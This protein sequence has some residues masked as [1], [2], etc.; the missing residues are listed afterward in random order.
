[1]KKLVLLALL[2]PALALAIYDMDTFDVNHWRTPV[3]NDGRWGFDVTGPGQ[4]GGTWPQPLHNCYVFGAGPWFGAIVDSALPETLCTHMYY[5]NS[6]GSE[7]SP[8]LC[9]YWRDG[10]EDSLD[11]IY[12]YP[13]DW[14]PPL[15]RFPM[16]PQVPRA[17]MEMWCGFGDSLAEN[18][19]P[20]GRPLGIDVYQTVY[21]F[22]DSVA[23]DFFFLKYELANCSGDSLRQA[24][25]GMMFDPDIGQHTDDM[26]GLIRDRLFQVGPD[27]IRVKDVGYAYDYDTIENPGS[28]WES[29]TPGIVAVMVLSTPESLGLTAFKKSLCDVEDT[30]TDAR[31]YMNLAGYD[32]ETGT[33]APYDTVDTVPGDKVELFATGPYDIAPDSVLT[34]WYV[35]IAS[36]CDLSELAR[37][38]KDATDIYEERLTGIEETPSAEARTPNGAT[39]VRG[40]LNL[41]PA[42][43]SPQSEIVLLDISGR[44]VMALRPGANDVRALAPGVYFVREAQAQD[45][46]KVLATK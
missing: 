36:P 34:F 7:M 24:Y 14:P 42:I 21:G 25:F 30:W 43:Y 44:K 16:A 35:V 29:G 2:V 11:R 40:V 10:T 39:I 23:Q 37:R 17:D 33:Y 5:Q 28:T 9:R 45:V 26:T 8:T 38:C 27:T 46:R 12:R 20:P 18:H 41:Q 4:A 13:G 31:Q 32:Y 22:S 15:S 19:V 3:H 1:M 6:A